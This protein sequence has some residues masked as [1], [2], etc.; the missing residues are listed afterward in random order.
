[1][2]VQEYQKKMKMYHNKVTESPLQEGTVQQPELLYMNI[3]S[4]VPRLSCFKNISAEHN[5]Q[6]KGYVTEDGQFVPPQGNPES[7]GEDESLKQSVGYFYGDAT[8]YE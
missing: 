6:K 2:S 4:Q 5:R 3:Y 1:M 8:A 7:D